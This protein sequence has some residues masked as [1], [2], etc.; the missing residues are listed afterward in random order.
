MSRL[1]EP[2]AVGPLQLKNRMVMAPLELFYTSDGIPNPKMIE[3]FR[4]RARGGIGLVVVGSV[5]VDPV[6]HKGEALYLFEAQH[7][8]GLKPLVDAIHEGGAKV[9]A[10]LLHEGRYARAADY[11]GLPPVAPSALPS[12]LTQETPLEMSIEDIQQMKAYYAHAARLAITAGFDGVELCAN[13]GYL[14]GQFLSPLTNQRTDAY[15]G[16]L[17]GRMRFLLET[18][19]AVRQALGTEYPL[20]VRMGGSDLMPGGNTGE[21][22]CHLAAALE[23]AGVDAISVTG[24]WH[25]SSIPQV[26]MEVP[27]AAFGY[28]A[29]AIK[30]RISIPVMASN[31][32]DFALGAELVERGDIDMVALAR[33]MLADPDG[34]N[35]ARAGDFDEIRP[36]IGCN[37]GCMDRAMRNQDVTCLVNA[38]AGDE[39]ALINAQGLLP[40]QMVSSHEK[41]LVIG[42]GVAGME[43]ARVAA[44]RGNEVVLW[45]KK[46]LAGGQVEV[47]S[48]PPGRGDFLRFTQ[49]L[50]RACS[51]AGVTIDY[52]KC[53]VQD[54][55][56]AAIKEH[57]FDRVVIATGAQPIMPKI[58][59]E[60]GAHVV[61]AWDVLSKRVRTGNHVA[62][63][64]GGAVGVET[65][66]LLAEVGTLSNEQ[67]RFLTM[68]GVES[69]EKLR[70]LLNR[71]SK[72]VSVIEMESV[73]G[74][75]IG[76]T[77]RWAMMA[78]LHSLG[79]H[80]HKSTKVLEIKKRGVLAECAAET[81]FIAADTVVL[82]IGSRADNAL[83]RALDGQVAKLHL[84]GD[85]VR[86]RKIQDAVKEAYQL[87]ISF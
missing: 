58:P 30:E 17:N 24:G 44:L 72:Q 60:P 5:Q 53:A 51:T 61:Q 23:H 31:R 50:L 57:G 65:A 39:A 63:V 41:I 49:Y 66:L 75:D 32:M 56:S 2:I 13:S 11:G 12:T 9:F 19:A 15:G 54:E 4:V 25:E 62:I 48:A 37:Q 34:P 79:V 1:F 22:T 85:A 87:A 33:P 86:P 6:R 76:L 26:T 27:P 78:R 43:F 73:I 81:Q 46:A 28:L 16:D 21:D 10:Q 35:K 42:A 45:E 38:E 84:I 70:S 3:F 82:A 68:Y 67:L 36:C 52:D 55:V 83:F 80:Q 29:R 7:A 71:G 18:V 69:G 77:S 20:T 14:I 47:V 8:D 74:R 59:I 40:S 64:G